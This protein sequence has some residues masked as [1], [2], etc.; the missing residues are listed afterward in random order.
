MIALFLS[1]TTSRP[2]HAW[3][4]HLVVMDWMQSRLEKEVPRPNDLGW[5]APLGKPKDDPKDRYYSLASLLLLNP[6]ADIRSLGETTPRALLRLSADD[7]DHGMDRELPDSADPNDDRKFMGG[8]IGTPSAGFRHMY[9]PGWNWRK[10]LATFQIPTRALG[11]APDRADLIANEARDHFRKGDSA[12]GFRLL[13]WA[14]HY[15]QDL[16]QPFHAVQLPSPRMVPWSALFAWPPSAG[17]EALVREATRT[18]TNYHWAYEGYVRHALRL[19]DTSPFRECFEKSG[20]SLL[21]S[22][23]RELAIEVTNRSI[24]RSRTVGKALLE[25][26]GPHLKKSGVSIPVDPGQVDVEALLRDPAYQAVRERLNRETCEALRLATDATV[27][28]VNWTL[29]SK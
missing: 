13:G 20:G 17:W 7:P 10:P 16:T 19:G 11:Q 3:Y 14:I 6:K 29:K 15:L 2:A 8:T 4:D 27:W 1:G 18:I 9:W 23:P 28:L 24:D 5:N 25:L 26:V 22:S 12:W 21:V